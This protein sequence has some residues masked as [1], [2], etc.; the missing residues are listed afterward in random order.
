[1]T[2]PRL[3][4][5]PPLFTSDQVKAWREEARRRREVLAQTRSPRKLAADAGVSEDAMRQL[6]DGKT[7]KWVSHG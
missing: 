4:G 1:L 2:R 6:L 3:T 5:R 7:Y